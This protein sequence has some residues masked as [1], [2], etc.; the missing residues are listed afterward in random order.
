MFLNKNDITALS[1]VLMNF[2]YFQ[3]FHNRF[4][5]AQCMTQNTLPNMS[6]SPNCYGEGANVRCESQHIKHILWL[7]LST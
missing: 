7:L 4:V 5:F 2:K 1:H 6:F 3:I